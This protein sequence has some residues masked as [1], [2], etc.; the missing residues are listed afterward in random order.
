MQSPRIPV[1]IHGQSV[2][3][4]FKLPNFESIFPALFDHRVDEI[5]QVFPR[6]KRLCK[7]L[8]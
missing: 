3:S 8:V 1:S 6:A 2:I 7:I 5:V 4:E